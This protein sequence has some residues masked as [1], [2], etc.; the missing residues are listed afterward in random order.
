[1]QHPLRIGT[2]GWR[3]KA[4]QGTFYDVDLPQEWQLSWYANHLRSVWVPAD[5]LYAI[6]LDEIAVW[7]EDTD[8]DFRFI[9]EIESASAYLET[10]AKHVSSAKAVAK[11]FGD[12]L[13][14]FVVD[15]KVDPIVEKTLLEQIRSEI[16]GVPV[17]LRGCPAQALPAGFGGCFDSCE[18]AASA[19]SP[20]TIVCHTDGDL[21]GVRTVIETMQQ[22]NTDSGALIFTDPERAFDHAVKARTVADLLDA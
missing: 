11:A 16:S 19:D 7:I 1:M 6:S 3:H 9:V 15:V 18:D 4:W 12:Q 14:A 2:R 5:R 21:V 20:Y 8:P 10:D 22:L 17:C 13:D